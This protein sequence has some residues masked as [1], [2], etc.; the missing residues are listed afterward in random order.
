MKTQ[1]AERIREVIDR[2]HGEGVLPP[3]DVPEIRVEWTKDERYGEFT[4]NIAL[5][6]AKSAKKPPME[7]AAMLAERLSGDGETV[8]AVAPGYVNIRLSQ[9]SMASVVTDILRDGSSYGNGRSGEGIRVNNEF[10]SANPTGPM[11][12]GN[13]RGGFFGDTLSNVL[14]KAGFDVTSEY[15]VND[16]GGQVMKLGH[17]V[18]RDA[19]AVYGGEYIDE[20]RAALGVGEDASVSDEAGVRE[21]GEQAADFVLREYI[22]KSL[23]EKMR[24]R[25]DS[26]VSERN[27]I[28]EKGLVDRAIG[29]F[30]EKELAYESEGA[31]WLRT[32]DFGDDK[33]RVLVKSDRERTYFAND[34]GYL[35]SK[36]ERGADRLILTLGADHHGYVARIRAAARA[37]GFEGRFD[38]H[39]VQ[40]VRLVKDGKE[41]RMSKRAGNVVTIDELVDRVGH[42]VARFFFLMPSLDSHMNFDL[43]LAEEHSEKNPVFY[44][45]YAH[46]R[47]S[48]ILRKAEESG[49]SASATG[50]SSL[51]HPK[52]R[53][54]MREL[55]FFP[56]LCAEVAESGAVH[57]LPQ[58]AIRLADRLHSFYADCRVIDEADI[59][60]SSARLALVSAVRTVLA[61]T[62]RLVGVSAPEKM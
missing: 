39:I 6:I 27:D 26:F 59:P 14:R 10:V 44:V 15:Y 58:Y 52:E 62:L 19:E 13:G 17:S 30:R 53:G 35:L 23:D 45:Q 8:E 21:L 57:R 41:V 56:E 9:V 60:L 24:I 11:H 1:W 36:I 47:L 25:Y 22:R 3:F 54:L 43:G 49:I 5:V 18:L 28:V 31:L 20:I 32:T 7:I 48:S 33:D 61:E 16:G 37:L 12:L 29:V 4:S 2:L 50:L 55:M 40:L 34:C 51:D 46:A 42:D 38:V